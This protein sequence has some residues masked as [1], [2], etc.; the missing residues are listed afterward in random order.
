MTR[1]SLRLLPP[2]SFVP[3][4]R[5]F[6]HAQTD[7]PRTMRATPRQ[8]PS[9]GDSIQPSQRKPE[10]T[11]YPPRRRLRCRADMARRVGF[12]TT[13]DNLR[14]LTPTTRLRLPP[15]EFAAGESRI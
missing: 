2:G 4:R 10:P 13:T 11:S 7:T 15:A 8:K 12:A 1:T 5:R 6:G 14:R 9:L 3:V